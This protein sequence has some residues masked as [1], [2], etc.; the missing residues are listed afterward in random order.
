[1][2][3]L[4]VELSKY[5]LIILF[6]V[7][8]YECFAVF[9]NISERKQEK[10]FKR[11]ARILY[12]IHFTA[13]LVI[14]AV[15]EDAYTFIFY[16]AQIIL[17]VVVRNV[18]KLCYPTASRLLVNNMCMLMIIGFIILTRLNFGHAIKQFA[19][20]A[21]SCVISLVIP[22]MIRRMGFFRNLTWIYAAIGIVGLGIVCIAGSTSYGAKISFTIAGITVQPSEFIKILF[23]FFVILRFFKFLH[24]VNESEINRLTVFGMV[25]DLL[26][27]A[28]GYAY[29][30]V[31]FLLNRTPSFA[32]NFLLLFETVNFSIEFAYTKTLTGVSQEK[33]ND[34]SDAGIT[35]SLRLSA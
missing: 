28:Q 2:V 14:F 3:H 32:E 20:A 27:L 30:T 6:S 19:I 34:L 5:A 16:L 18:Y 31:L 21:V 12:V 7:Y 4:I 29:N 9:R 13:Y 33:P 8:T 23:V 15:T 11:Q 10:K 25:Y 1:M 17:L 22:V 26:D 24:L 35:I